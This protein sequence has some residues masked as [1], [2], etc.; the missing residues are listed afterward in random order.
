[1]SELGFEQREREARARDEESRGENPAYAEK[2]RLGD[3]FADPNAMD[4][5]K[6]GNAF[7]EAN[8][9]RKQKHELH[10]KQK[11]QPKGTRKYLVSFL[12]A[13]LVLF[14][15]VFVL[16]ILPR[17]RRDKENSERAQREK[18]R[19]PTVEVVKIKAEPGGAGLTI[20]GTTTPMTEAFVYA[21]ANGYLKRRL[22]DIGDHVKKGQLLAVI[23]APDLDQQVDQAR[24]QVRQAE[25]Q[26]AQQQ[27][28]LALNKITW[29]RYRVLVAK[30]VLARQEGDQRE[31]DYLAQQ[32]NVAAAERNV[33][34]YQANLRRVIALQSYEQVRAPF[35][36]VVTA[37]NVDVGALISAAGSSSGGSAGPSQAGPSAGQQGGALTNSAGS[38]GSAPT[39]SSPSGGGDGSGAGALFSIAQVERLRILIS[40]PE[41]YAS[42]VAPG[43]HTLLHFQE[44]PKQEFHGDVTRTAASIDQNTRTLLTE[45]QVDNRAGHLMAGM[46]AVVTFAESG[47]RGGSGPVTI[48]GDAL[49]VRE[50]NTVVAVVEDGKIR[51]QPVEIGRDFG[52]AMEIVNGLKVGDVIATTIT[53]DVTDGAKVQTKESKSETQSAGQQAPAATKALPGG[54]SQYG[55]QSLT[56]QNQQGQGSQKKPGGQGGK[57]PA[58]GSGSKP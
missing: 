5:T 41:G 16:G 10:L 40:V 54:S 24:E 12:V 13:V 52:A 28:Q 58:S 20:P 21:R 42:A 34:A 27:T 25:A 31:A 6:L 23:D 38:S 18:D 56:D 9:S 46:Y 8:S 55:D 49:V 19:V 35:D 48:P 47:G 26:V 33:Q 22:V 53:D 51:M 50:N 15:L 44:F 2:K 45:V 1:M 7:T 36:G 30:G 57:K 29:D 17:L 14:A 37:R 43:Q 32:A 39:A 3:A 11:L 4:D